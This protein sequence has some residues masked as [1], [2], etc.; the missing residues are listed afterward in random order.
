MRRWFEGVVVIL[1]I[2]AVVTLGILMVTGLNTKRMGASACDYYDPP[3][4]A[5]VD[6]SYENAP[7]ASVT[8]LPFALEC[9]YSTSSGER[10]SVVRDMGSAPAIASVA[11]LAGAPFV[12]A[13][14][15]S[16]REPTQRD[17][18]QASLA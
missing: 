17:D 7:R 3:L 4:T 10:V 15:R 1:C 9:S 13:R 14:R 2:G 5:V 12:W 8:A 18:Q 6:E 11:V 16:R